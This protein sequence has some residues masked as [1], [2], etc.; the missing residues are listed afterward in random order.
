MEASETLDKALLT[1]RLRWGLTSMWMA[2]RQSLCLVALRRGEPVAALS[3]TIRRTDIRTA[4]LGS[5]QAEAAAKGGTAL[6]VALAVLA[7][8]DKISVTG[9]Y[10]P[11]EARPYHVLIGRRLDEPAPGDSSWTVEDCRLIVKKCGEGI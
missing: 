10:T 5:R 6:E 9:T 3:Y 4:F 1:R 8:R 11:A 7:V 2:L